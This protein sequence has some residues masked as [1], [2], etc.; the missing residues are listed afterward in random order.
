MG[1]WILFELTSADVSGALLLMNQTGCEI[2]DVVVTGEMTLRFL[3]DKGSARCLREILE[4]RGDR[5]RPL[6]RLGLIRNVRPWGR[7]PVLLLGISLLLFLTLWLPTRVLFIR[8]EGNSRIPANQILEQAELCG[9]TFGSLRSDVR[10]ERMKNA[11]LEAMPQL[12]WAGI[13]TSGCVATIT[14]RERQPEPESTGNPVTGIT[15]SR[16]GVIRTCTVRRG[17]AL[18]APGQA[19]RSGEMLISGLTDCGLVI[20]A[21]RAE[22]EIFAETTRA[23]LARTPDSAGF[24]SENSGARKNFSLIIG[25]NRINFYNDS[26]ILDSSCVKMYEEYYLTLPGG[27]RLPIGLAVETVIQ[28]E[29][30]QSGIPNAGDTLEGYAR[31]Y[32]QAHMVAGEI[33]EQ[34]ITVENNRL[35][36]DYICLE[37]IG[38]NRYEEFIGQDGKIDGENG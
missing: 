18:C 14:V 3:S 5:L 1:E 4:R 16:D 6:R 22:G 24:R 30:A 8:V 37:M 19:V 9:I 27:F 2:R 10:S 31:S 20:L 21:D 25:K 32:L 28:W 23:V 26:G 29:C 36:A 35:Y 17:N 13:N 12:Q 33:L 34:D 7:H 15:A 38:Q 11:L